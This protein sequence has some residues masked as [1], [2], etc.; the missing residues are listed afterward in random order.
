MFEQLVAEFRHFLLVY[1]SQTEPLRLFLALVSKGQS[2]IEAFNGT[3]LLKFAIRQLKLVQVAA[4]GHSADD[5]P[6]TG[7]ARGG[8]SPIVDR[9]G[10]GKERAVNQDAAA[11]DGADDDDEDGDRLPEHGHA[12]KPTKLSPVWFAV[13]G[14]MLHVSQSYQPAISE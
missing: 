1:P 11:D 3:R 14:M 6:K 13:Y 8:S 5:G 9:K 7:A 4:T 2:A 12:F 10:K